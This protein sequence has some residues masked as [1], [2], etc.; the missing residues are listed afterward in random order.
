M[1][2]QLIDY[3]LPQ[4]LIAQEPAPRREA[5]RLL[6]LDRRGGSIEHRRFHEVPSLL[7]PGDLLVVNDTLVI[8]ARLRALRPSGGAVEVFLLEEESPRIFRTLL[9]PG[10][11]GRA[12]RELQLAGDPSVRVRVLGRDGDEFRAA[13]SRGGRDLETAEVH[14]VCEAVGETPLPPYIH[15]EV[16]D[17]RRAGDRERYQTVFAAR[18]GAVAAPTAGLHFSRELLERIE[19][20]GVEIVKI[21]LHV[22]RDT[23]K[24]LTEREIESGELHGEPMEIGIDAGRRLR[25]AK[26]QGRRIVAVGTTCVRALESFALGSGELPH[27]ARTR[28]FIRPGHEFRMVDALITN[29]HLPRSSLLLL[30][31]AFAGREAILEAYREAIA[32]EYRFYSYGDAMLIR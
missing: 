3:D 1:E 28:L 21:T 16:E 25:A 4:R 26:D 10:K 14:A 9:R 12:G 27:R 2:P 18:P 15:R 5:S 11:A 24:P 13:F 31:S 22:G 32:M 30:V 19:E 17:A 6:V 29:F 20:R 23:F 8:P 7:G